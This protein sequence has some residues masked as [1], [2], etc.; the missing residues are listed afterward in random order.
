MLGKTAA[1]T[2]LTGKTLVEPTL[3]VFGLNDEHMLPHIYNELERDFAKDYRNWNTFNNLTRAIRAQFVED[4]ADE[5]ICTLHHK[6]NGY[7]VIT[8]INILARLT[9]Y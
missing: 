7:T 8:P 5:Y 4:I 3:P 9:E 6:Y 1:F 2:A